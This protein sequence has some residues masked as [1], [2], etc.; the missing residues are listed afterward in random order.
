MK[1]Q[2][3]C[4]M[5]VI[6]VLGGTLPVTH[7]ASSRSVS[8]Y[9]PPT[10]V[11]ST[12][13]SLSAD[14]DEEGQPPSTLPDP[15]GLPP[16]EERTRVRQAAQAVLDEYNERQE[17]P[18]QMV[19]TEVKVEGDWAYAVAQPQAASDEP[20]YLLAHR[21]ADGAWQALIPSEDGPYLQWLDVVPESLMLSGEKSQLRTHAAQVDDLR[22][23]QVIPLVPPDKVPRSYVDDPKPA[24]AS[25]SSM[26]TPMPFVDH[27]QEQNLPDLEVALDSALSVYI[28]QIA[29]NHAFEISDTHVDQGWAYAVA[30]GL[31]TSGQRV[32]Y[33]FIVLLARQDPVMGWYAVAPEISSAQ[34]YNA[35]LD[36]FPVSLLDESTKAYLH[37]PESSVQP[38]SLLNFG[39]HKLPWPDDQVG[40]L[41]KKDN[42]YCS[43]GQVKCS[44]SGHENQVDFGIPRD[45]FASKPGTVVFAKESSD[46]GCCSLDCWEQANMVVVQHSD[47]EYSWYVHLA[48]NSV[49]VSAGAT[50]GFGTKI[51]EEGDTGYACGAHLHYMVSHSIPSSWPDLANPNDAPWPP[52]GSIAAVDFA[53]VSWTDL[54]LCQP[55]TSQ[56]SSGSGDS[57]PPD[58]DINSP[59]EGATITN[60][61]VDLAGWG[62]DSQSGFNHAQFIGMVQLRPE[63]S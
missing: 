30:Y 42:C 45:V 50:V 8:A 3:A 39:G 41:T 63:I 21:G 1:K 18:Y 40:T 13:T 43:N 12:L 54:E 9:A 2:F 61:T 49:P 55:Y 11:P 14:S 25:L 35:W 46:D 23:S 47:S 10:P 32:P 62:S 16:E 36:M 28:Q 15:V 27:R 52:G 59:S 34:E 22:W 7:L 48:Y 19:V 4:A 53:E 20:V 37:R 26:G 57:T 60:R 38:L 5:V 31:D 29:P 24:P 56:N 17:L 6:L 33:Q 58:G 51:G 44:G